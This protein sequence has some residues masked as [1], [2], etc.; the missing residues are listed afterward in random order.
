[1]ANQDLKLYAAGKGVKQWQVAESF[2]QKP[3]NFSMS[4][5]NEW[6]EDKKEEYRSIV[7]KLAADR[8]TA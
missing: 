6:P 7:D 8:D 2:G 5:R 4:L 1:M 3:S